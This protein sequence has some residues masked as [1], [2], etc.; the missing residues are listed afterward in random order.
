M[1]SSYAV[2]EDCTRYSRNIVIE[3]GGYLV[4]HG[5]KNS[6]EIEFELFPDNVYVVSIVRALVDCVLHLKDLDMD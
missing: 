4:V 5:G 1:Y 6:I 3:G 2:E